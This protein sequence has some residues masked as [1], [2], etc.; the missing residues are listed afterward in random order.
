MFL[1]KSDTYEEKINT[2]SNK[3]DEVPSRNSRIPH[4]CILLRIMKDLKCENFPYL[5]QDCLAPYHTQTQILS[6]RFF[7]KLTKINN[8]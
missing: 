7:Q 6:L 1:Q 3:P 8:S 4:N 5:S 2:K